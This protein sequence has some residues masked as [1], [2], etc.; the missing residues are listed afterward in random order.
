MSGNEYSF[1]REIHTRTLA[2]TTDDDFR[3]LRDKRHLPLQ[4]LKRHK[5]AFDRV[6][7]CWLIPAMSQ[8]GEVLNLTRYYLDSGNK[9]SLPCLP[10]R[11]FG[12]D[13]LGED[14]NKPLLIVEGPWDAIA[15]DH[16]LREKKTRDRYEILAVPSATIFDPE[17]V[18]YL[19][20]ENRL[21][22]DND[23]A[24]RD[25]QQ[26]IIKIV[27]QA[28]LP[29][30]LYALEWPE[31]Y[32][33]KCD[34]GD[35]IHADINV[36]E[37]THDHCKKV[38]AGDRRI[39][40]QRGDEIPEQLVEWLWE[41]HITFATFVSF[42]GLMGTQKSTIIRALAAYATAGLPMPNCTE[43][44]PPMDVMIFTSEDAGSRVRDIVR[45]HGGDLTRLHVYDIASGDGEPIDILE[46]LEEMEAAINERGCKLVILDALNSF[47]GGDI[48]TD[49]KARRTLSGRLQSL[50]RRTGA[51]IVGIRNWGR[52]DGGTSSQKSLG[53]TSLSDVGRVVMNTQELEQFESGARR[54]QLEFEKVT[55]A[56]KPPSIPYEVE[57]LSTGSDDSHHRR[58]IWRKP[59]D[60]AKLHDALENMSHKKG[61]KKR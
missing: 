23:K 20:R 51:C 36:V 44:L 19:K 22:L 52:M 4:T 46:R 35:L 50:A 47:V 7:N 8:K 30:E 45:I 24:G 31:E 18:K 28:K 14:D 55:D 58:I 40:F 49:S 59:F 29:C 37:F 25:G 32:P 21:C 16:H 5:L 57:N 3:E 43:A 12:L 38:A 60:P 10:M 9:L 6:R 17:W 53:A 33:D 48:S 11:P 27:E 54:F 26:R 56:P 13:A 15:L 2:D 39:I 34:I 61:S 41:G 1:I 42:S